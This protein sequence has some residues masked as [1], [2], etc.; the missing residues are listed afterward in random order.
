MVLS[1]PDQEFARRT[2]DIIDK[3][4]EYEELTGKDCPSYNYTLG[5]ENAEAWYNDLSKA[6]EEAKKSREG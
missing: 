5:Y 3:L 4:Y 6:I 1:I 2:P